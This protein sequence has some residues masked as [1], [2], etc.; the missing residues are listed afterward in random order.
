MIEHA[1]SHPA[2]GILGDFAGRIAVLFKALEKLIDRM[3][4]SVEMGKLVF[5][6]AQPIRDRGNLALERVDGAAILLMHHRF[7]KALIEFV[8]SALKRG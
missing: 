2:C 7:G 8:D 1:V 4:Q 5:G 6:L 3:F